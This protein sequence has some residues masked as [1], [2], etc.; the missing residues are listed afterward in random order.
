ML[1]LKKSS[2]EAEASMDDQEAPGKGAGKGK[3]IA[4][5]VLA[6]V[7]G[8]LVMDTLGVGQSDASEP[9]VV[10]EASFEPVKSEPAPAASGDSGFTN[11]DPF[12]EAPQ[13]AARVA[14]ATP[15]APAAADVAGVA[16]TSETG[17]SSESS[18]ERVSENPISASAAPNND[19][20]YLALSRELLLARKRREIAEERAAEMKLRAEMNT[21]DSGG[22][23]AGPDAAPNMSGNPMMPGPGLAGNGMSAPLSPV[24]GGMDSSNP[25]TMLPEFA[26]P[27]LSVKYIGFTAGRWSALLEDTMQKTYRVFKGS[28]VR[29]NLVAD[30]NRKGVT[31][32]DA[33]GRTETLRRPDYATPPS[34]ASTGVSSQSDDIPGA[35]D[36]APGAPAG[37]NM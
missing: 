19:T 30:I 22:M 6:P 5:V 2:K 18:A 3:V 29:G 20:T 7:V 35:P 1:G 28:E 4:L 36:S 34:T 15:T 27:D 37:L 9:E 33:S 26:N 16:D 13:P 14:D 10:A 11:D 25:N 21:L 31:L 17:V 23:M 12:G 24:T 32:K 8:W